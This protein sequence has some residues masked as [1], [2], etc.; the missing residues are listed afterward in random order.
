MW[1]PFHGLARILERALGR[2]Y[3]IHMFGHEKV[4]ITPSREDSSYVSRATHSW[5][6]GCTRDWLELQCRSPCFLSI[7]AL[8]NL[9]AI[10]LASLRTCEGIMTIWGEIIFFRDSKLPRSL[11]LGKILVG[12]EPSF[13]LDSMLIIIWESP[14]TIS[15]WKQS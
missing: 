14:S 9:S 10:L 13:S 1:C 6:R 4:D 15:W 12:S 8:T 3:A 2:E 11:Q 5:K 7:L